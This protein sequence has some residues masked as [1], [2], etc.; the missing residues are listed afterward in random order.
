MTYDTG[1]SF[2]IWWDQVVAPITEISAPFYSVDRSEKEHPHMKYTF[3][4]QR[5]VEVLLKQIMYSCYVCNTIAKE[6]ISTFLGYTLIRLIL[7][8][9]QKIEVYFSI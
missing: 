8:K 9:I 6:Q 5:P 3:N 2:A 7:Q 1:M 4:L